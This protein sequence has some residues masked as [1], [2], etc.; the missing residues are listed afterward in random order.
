MVMREKTSGRFDKHQT[1]EESAYQFLREHITSG[2]LAPGTKLVGSRL[3]AELHVSRLTIA[4]ALKRLISE[5]FVEGSP[6]RE[7]VVASL[8][9]RDLREIFLIRH[10]LEDVVMEEAA[11]NISPAVLARLR[12]LN[13]QLRDSIQRQDAIAYRRIEREYH[14]L[15]YAAAELSMVGGILTDLW[16]RFEPYRGRR[17]SN[18]RLNL[19]A[20]TDHQAI[21]DALEARAGQKVAHVMR[22]HVDQGYERFRL[23]LYGPNSVET[24]QAKLSH[25]DGP[26]RKLSREQALISGSL[27]AALVELPDTR[28]GQG[29]VHNQ[30]SILV[31]AVCAMLCGVRSRYG[32]AWWGQNCHPSIRTILGLPHDQGP[33]IATVHRLFSKLDSA[34]FEQILKR[35]FKENGIEEN[36]NEGFSLE[37]PEAKAPADEKLPGVAFISRI[38][39]FLQA[40]ANQN[41]NDPT[42]NTL[43]RKLAELPILI[44]AGKTTPATALLAQR[45]LMQQIQLQNAGSG[46]V[47]LFENVKL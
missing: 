1:L 39:Y 14:L 44:L 23:A 47:N 43:Y 18:I 8:N 16:D 17:Y 35:W 2:E 4:N 6:H 5:G 25:R 7:S 27:R 13:E 24:D 29:K 34:A 28:R 41:Y 32:I 26:S 11:R 33:S 42:T 46:F 38:A 20:Y 19:D 9:E 10:A 21:H 15:I 45:E 40:A 31:L 36:F 3:A 30:S 22:A 12:E 37:M